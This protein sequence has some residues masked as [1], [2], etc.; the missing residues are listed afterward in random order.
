M[1]MVADPL[2][3]S[4][5]LAR[6]RV[7][8]PAEVVTLV[9]P[10]ALDLA[11]LHETGRVHGA[12][13][14][15]AVGFRADG[16]PVLRPAR[17]PDAAAGP[18]DDVFA[19]AV[20]GYAALDGQPAARLVEALRAGLTDDP[21]E[22]CAA[23]ELAELVLA[24]GPAA[25]LR[26][27]Y[28]HDHREMTRQEPGD[29]TSSRW[30]AA[31]V[32]VA[33][34]VIA[35]PRAPLT[36]SWAAVVARLDEA[37]ALAIGDRNIAELHAVYADGSEPLVRDATLIAELVR[38]GLTVRGRLAELSAPRVLAVHAGGATLSV[39][40]RP[41]VYTLIDRRGRVV[42]RVRGTNARRIVV[43]LRRT[44]AGWRVTSVS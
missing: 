11:E 2:R 24:A 17:E 39:L 32:V 9:V 36:P 42:V 29:S 4:D 19:L 28:R 18:A 41:A 3:L 43:R 44:A 7:L 26:L 16:R 21:R 31:A 6:R 22:R 37:R 20:L 25:P 12:V 40:E 10:L 35:W 38:R 15:D 23:R 8:A 1:P 27:P 30:R 13:S 34:A 33:L 5:V 14:A